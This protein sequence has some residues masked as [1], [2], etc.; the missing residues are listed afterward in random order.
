V[1][2]PPIRP[3]EKQEGKARTKIQQ[4]LDKAWDD[5]RKELHGKR[6]EIARTGMK[7][8]SAVQLTQAADSFRRYIKILEEWKKVPEGGLMPS[9]FDAK[10]D[11]AE[12]LLLSGVYWDLV[13]LYDRTRTDAKRLEMMHYID[14]FYVF[15]VGLPHHGVCVET[16]RKYIR[17]NRPIHKKEFREL[18]EKMGG[19]NC[20]VATSLID[21]IDLSTLDVL[22]LWRDETLSHHPVGRGFIRFYYKVGPRLA[23]ITNRMPDAIRY[24]LAKSLN[25]FVSRL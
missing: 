1:A 7:E 6:I 13:K 9:H 21:V 3:S 12:L 20:F 25:W 15:S 22:Y 2:S 19:K 16:V 5:Y 11:A 24:V 17:A 8:Y 10:T 4:T 18:Y 14:K 23:W